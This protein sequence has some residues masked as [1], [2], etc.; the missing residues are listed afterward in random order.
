MKR[1]LAA[2]LLTALLCSSALAEGLLAA[3]F[4]PDTP[5]A[6][7][8][9]AVARAAGLALD[10]TEE[11]D[12]AAAANA[13]LKSPDVLLFSDQAVM[14]AGM[15]GYTDEDVRVAMQPVCRIA[16]SPLY[17]VMDA[18]AARDLGIGNGADWMDYIAANEY[19]LLL[20]RH[21]DADVIDRAATLL[22]DELPV[23]TEYY[24]VEEIPDVLAAGE[25]QA[26]VFSWGEMEAL[27]R[28][29]LLILCS[30]GEAR[31]AQTP[32]IPCAQELGMPP[33]QPIYLYVFA[34]AQAA[35]EDVARAAEACLAISPDMVNAL[36]GFAFSPLSGEALRQE[37]ARTFADYKRYMTAEGLF[38][39]EE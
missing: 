24:L 22:S 23:L 16:H 17:L 10:L 32:D 1:I 39:Y 21:T 20:A 13:M 37:I 27:D 8:A 34:S 15:Q 5:P 33:C 31:E 29:S 6:A 35:A 36:P 9:A 18:A 4:A 7:I 30:L 25:A 12:P 38:F 28:D 26:A 2:A 11:A 19:E 14:F 3:P